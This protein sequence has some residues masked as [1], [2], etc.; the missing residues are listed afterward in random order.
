[1]DQGVDAVDFC[2]QVYGQDDRRRAF[3]D[4]AAVILRA[5]LVAD[6]A[7]RGTSWRDATTL[8]TV[9]RMKRKRDRG[10]RVKRRLVGSTGASTSGC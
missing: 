4:F 1:M 5:E 8:T 6:I 7:A 3:G 10:W 2:D 9:W